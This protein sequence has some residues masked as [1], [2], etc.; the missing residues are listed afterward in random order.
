MVRLTPNGLSVSP[1]QRA[2]SLTRSSGV[3]W[4]RAVMKP[5]APALATAATSSGRPTHCMPPCT[6]GCSTPTSSVNRVLNM[7]C[8]LGCLRCLHRN[9]PRRG[10]PR[11]LVGRQDAVR[12]GKSLSCTGDEPMRKRRARQPKSAPTSVCPTPCGGTLYAGVKVVPTLHGRR[13]FL[14]GK[15]VVCRRFGF[16]HDGIGIGD[17][18][19]LNLRPYHVHPFKDPLDRDVARMNS[20]NGGF[21]RRSGSVWHAHLARRFLDS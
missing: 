6:I 7:A 9:F 11:T 2:I 1:P 20:G 14:A 21:E 13:G 5:S 15:P 16:D 17:V 8:P 4:V 18:S 19:H 3:G 10:R 12:T